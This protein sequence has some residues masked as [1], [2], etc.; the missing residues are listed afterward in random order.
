MNKYL[1]III[2]KILITIQLCYV[3]LPSRP[4]LLFLIFK[5]CTKKIDF[6]QV[7][8]LFY[9]G[10]F[11]KIKYRYTSF[12]KY[13]LNFL[14][15]NP[16]VATLILLE[17]LKN[18][19]SKKNL[20][21]KQQL[22]CVCLLVHAKWREYA[23]PPLFCAEQNPDACKIAELFRKLSKSSSSCLSFLARSD[24]VRLTAELVAEIEVGFEPCSC[25]PL[26][27]CDKLI[28]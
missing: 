9:T 17:A 12:Q 21:Y 2:I 23:C 24:L 22:K 8:N 10:N 1:I 27:T 7:N 20:P 3:M 4:V 6:K 28:L 14:K 11:K 16:H 19:H 18:S 25:G 15:L 5:I 13:I 26:G